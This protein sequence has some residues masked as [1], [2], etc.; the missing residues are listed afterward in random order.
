MWLTVPCICCLN[1]YNICHTEITKFRNYSYESLEGL[2]YVNVS[3]N[4]FEHHAVNHP[5]EKRYFKYK[6]TNQLRQ[7]RRYH[8]CHY[9]GCAKCFD[10]EIGTSHG[11]SMAKLYRATMRKKRCILSKNFK[12][13][14]IWACEWLRLRET[15][16][17]KENTSVLSSCI[18]HECSIG[19][20]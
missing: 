1:Q 3:K 18:S 6:S 4:T 8:D 13:E 20:V 11:R 17:C 9:R 19:I 5:E 2:F 7:L 10:E 12:Y 15:P 16:A 14:Y